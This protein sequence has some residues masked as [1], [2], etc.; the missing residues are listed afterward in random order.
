MQ[1]AMACAWA[2]QARAAWKAHGD[3]EHSHSLEWGASGDAAAPDR[4]PW[5]DAK[6]SGFLA[7]QERHNL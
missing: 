5:I 3:A 1:L 7:G 6:G 4:A 2:L